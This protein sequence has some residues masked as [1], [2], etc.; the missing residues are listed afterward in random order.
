MNESF[1][2]GSN[3][4]TSAT[5]SAAAVYFG[6][7]AVIAVVVNLSMIAVYLKNKKV[8]FRFLMQNL[9]IAFYDLC[10]CCQVVFVLT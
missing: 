3:T 9:L 2:S 6:L 4:L 8:S 1:E 7:V 10:P 5:Y